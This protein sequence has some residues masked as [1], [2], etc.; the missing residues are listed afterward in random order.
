VQAVSDTSGLSVPQ[1]AT[2]WVL[3]NPTLVS[4][5]P[6]ASSQSQL[7]SNMS[8]GSLVLTAEVKKAL[9]DASAELG[10]AMGNQIDIYQSDAGQRS[11]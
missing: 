5:I 7:D 8:A 10:V 2:A 11:F 3:T 9:D 1:L 6:G 4:V